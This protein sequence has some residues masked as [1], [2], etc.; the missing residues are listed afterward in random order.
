MNGSTKTSFYKENSCL[1]S[2]TDEFYGNY[3]SE[4]LLVII[5]FVRN[6]RRGSTSQLSLWSQCYTDTKTL[7]EK[8][9]QQQQKTTQ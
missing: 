6:W 5:N 1:D 7:K 4:I 8:K 3:K 2:V 9:N